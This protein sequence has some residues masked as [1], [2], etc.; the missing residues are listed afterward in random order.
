MTNNTPN[1]YSDK[2]FAMMVNAAS[3]V[4]FAKRGMS[5]VKYTRFNKAH[6]N[7]DAAPEDLSEYGL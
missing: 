1:E 2:E 4:F 5:D 6:L 7:E 3:A